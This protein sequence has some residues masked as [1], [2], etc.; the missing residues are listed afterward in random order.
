MEVLSRV[1]KC[2]KTVM[3]PK[4]KI[5]VLGKLHPGMNY[6]ATGREFKVNALTLYI[7]VSLNRNI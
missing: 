5:C 4:E 2:K 3:F 6:G 7:K 1:P